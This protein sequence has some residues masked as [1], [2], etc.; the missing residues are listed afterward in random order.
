MG[1]S[2]ELVDA[3]FISHTGSDEMSSTAVPDACARARGGGWVGWGGQKCGQIVQEGQVAC[4]CTSDVCMSS[5]GLV[6]DLLQGGR[7]V[8]AWRRCCQSFVCSTPVTHLSVQLRQA[9]HALPMRQSVSHSINWQNCLVGAARLLRLSLRG[10]MRYHKVYA[11]VE[12]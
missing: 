9:M 6:V 2:I 7:V 10:T 5:K 4:C 8:A 1:R 12:V 3:V 11:L